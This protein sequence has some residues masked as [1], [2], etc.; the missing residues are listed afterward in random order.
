MRTINVVADVGQIV[1]LELAKDLEAIVTAITIREEGIAYELTWLAAGEVQ[2]AWLPA[3]AIHRDREPQQIG[4][5]RT[6]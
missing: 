2:S 5:S 3:S 4:F 1:R 6:T